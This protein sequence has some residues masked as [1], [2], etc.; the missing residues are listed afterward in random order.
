MTYPHIIYLYSVGV[1]GG[2]GASYAFTDNLS[3]FVDYVELYNDETFE[4]GEEYVGHYW[5]E[6]EDT[7]VYTVNFGVT[8]KF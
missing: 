8:Y 6:Q 1:Y 5:E 4:S 2:A 7:K 3:F